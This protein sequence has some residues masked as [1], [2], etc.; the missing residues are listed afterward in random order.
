M[1]GVKRRRGRFPRA[2]TSCAPVGWRLELALGGAECRPAHWIRGAQAA[3]G[4]EKMVLFFRRGVWLLYRR[5]FG[6]KELEL[7]SDV[8][9]TSF[10]PTLME[11]P[12]PCLSR[13][14][15]VAWYIARDALR[16]F[17]SVESLF[18]SFAWYTCVSFTHWDHQPCIGRTWPCPGLAWPGE[19][20]EV[21]RSV[22]LSSNP[23]RP[24]VKL[25]SATVGN[26]VPRLGPGHAAGMRE[27]TSSGSG[28]TWP[29]CRN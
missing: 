24:V 21:T 4:T 8:V 23:G 1:G 25:S 12:S 27:R 13:R 26:R 11:M 5:R 19:F 28:T 3:S 15:C 29:R 20:N 2:R 7:S 10:L 6:L 22:R 17:L 14:T 16:C 18:V 9:S